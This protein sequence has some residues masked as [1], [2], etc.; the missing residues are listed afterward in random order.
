MGEG[1]K[2]KVQRA[3]AHVFQCRHA[4]VRERSAEDAEGFECGGEVGWS[5]EDV[6]GARVELLLHAC[7][8]PYL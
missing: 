4:D 3:W 1:G 6:R 7:M 8:R 2:K 5:Y